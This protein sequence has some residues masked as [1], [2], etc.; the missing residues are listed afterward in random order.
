MRSVRAADIPRLSSFLLRSSK[1]ILWSDEYQ[2]AFK[3]V[4]AMLCS[5]PVLS[6]PD[7]L[8]GFKIEVDGSATGAG[9]VLLQDD[10][11]VEHPA[12][13]FLKVFTTPKEIQYH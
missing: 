2:H 4:K 9:A 3:S 13:Y 7:Y 5:A 10:D 11:G 12:A 8:C 1:K 6:A